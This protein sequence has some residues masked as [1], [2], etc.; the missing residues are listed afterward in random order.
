M[1]KIAVF[2]H[3]KTSLEA[4][5]DYTGKLVGLVTQTVA[6]AIEEINETKADKPRKIQTSILKSGW[7]EDDGGV[8][9]YHYDIAVADITDEDV[10]KIIISPESMEVARLCELCGTNETLDGKIRIWA[11]SIPTAE[12]VVDCWI[13][14]QS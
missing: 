7:V 4:A 1:G 9:Q 2:E 5:R 10:A 3:L 6:E 13:E 12:I 14:H 11:V 8:Y